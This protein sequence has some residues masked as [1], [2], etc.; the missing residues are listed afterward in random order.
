MRSI[1]HKSTEGLV[2][3]LVEVGGADA[4]GATVDGKHPILA[5]RAKG[6]QLAAQTLADAANER[7]P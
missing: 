2:V 5:G 6:N 1:V 4:M 3:G 7:K